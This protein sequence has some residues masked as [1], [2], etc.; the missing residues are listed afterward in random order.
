MRAGGQGG[1]QGGG[2]ISF[3][4]VP[5]VE[6]SESFDSRAADNIQ[7]FVSPAYQGGNPPSPPPPQPASSLRPGTSTS[8]SSSSSGGGG[9]SSLSMSSISARGYYFPQDSQA[10]SS[11][12]GVVG[13]WGTITQEQDLQAATT[14]TTI[15]NTMTSMATETGEE[16]KDDHNGE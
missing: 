16:G 4:D 3:M 14:T 7:N 13:Q 1:G 6:E 9:I 15:T 8:S 12:G 2:H 10:S 5:L 11:L